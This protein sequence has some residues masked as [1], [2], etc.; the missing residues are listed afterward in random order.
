MFDT[1]QSLIILGQKIRKRREELEL[2]QE[3]LAEKC[4]L[5]ELTS[6]F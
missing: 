2:S 6:V 3:K 4:D 5:T 1:S